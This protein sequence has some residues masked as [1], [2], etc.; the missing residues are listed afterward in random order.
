MNTRKSKGMAIP[1]A[2]GLCLPD[3]SGFVLLSNA[4]TG[5][6]V[7]KVGAVQVQFAGRGGPVAVVVFQDGGDA[8]S[9]KFLDRVAQ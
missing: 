9:L 2:I 8:S 6:Q 1:I 3:G 5:G 7:V 4:E